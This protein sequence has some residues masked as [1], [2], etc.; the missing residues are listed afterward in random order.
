VSRE[1]VSARVRANRLNAARSTGPRTAEG[2]AR[3]SQN[4]LIH[5][6]RSAIGSSD[7]PRIGALADFLAGE[8]APAELRRAALD[9]ADA[10]FTAERARGLIE[11]ALETLLHDHPARKS[12]QEILDGFDDVVAEV[13]DP[14]ERAWIRGDHPVDEEEL[15]LLAKIGKFATELRQE[16]AEA[17]LR[18][19]RLFIAYR[20]RAET[21]Q[22]RAARDLLRVKARGG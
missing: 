7:D 18:D 9:V 8:E 11:E 13:F 1:R 2:K 10:N 22:A 17:L 3:S 5:G 16:Q 4:A 12:L 14:E 21:R 19:I 15:E 6:L 20:I